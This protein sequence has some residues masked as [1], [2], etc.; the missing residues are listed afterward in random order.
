MSSAA[1]AYMAHWNKK[2]QFIQK[3]GKDNTRRVNPNG[4]NPYALLLFARKT[5]LKS[6][7]APSQI[8]MTLGH[9]S[10]QD[11]Q[12]WNL[13]PLYYRWNPELNCMEVAKKRY[14]AKGDKLPKELDTQEKKDAWYYPPEG[15]IEYVPLPPGSNLCFN[16]FGGESMR[17]IEDSIV[18]IMDLV[19]KLKNPEKINEKYDPE[20][21]Q[22]FFSNLNKRVGKFKP[23]A[24]TQTM[25]SLPTAMFH[26]KNPAKDQ[27]QQFV[28]LRCYDIFDES[29]TTD[30]A[31][32]R[33]VT[34]TR[35]MYSPSD[36]DWAFESKDKDPVKTL[37]VPI[38]ADKQGAGSNAKKRNTKC[39]KVFAAI[40]QRVGPIDS[41]VETISAKVTVWENLIEEVFHVKDVVLW[42][43]VM[44][45]VAS[46]MAPAVLL[47]TVGRD[48]T[49]NSGW[50][51]NQEDDEAGEFISLRTEEDVEGEGDKAAA[52]GSADKPA[53]SQDAVSMEDLERMLASKADEKKA[54][55]AQETTIANQKVDFFLDVTAQ[56]AW[57]DVYEVYRR[58][59][60]PV[61]PQW[62]MTPVMIN[63]RKDFRPFIASS[64]ST[65]GAFDFKRIKE[66]G[67]VICV[68]EWAAKIDNL[69]GFCELVTKGLGEFR[70]AVNTSTYINETLNQQLIKAIRTFTPQDGADFLDGKYSKTPVTWTRPENVEYALFFLNKQARDEKVVVEAVG[71]AKE[72]LSKFIRP[73]RIVY[74]AEGHM[75]GASMNAGAASQG[76][77][78]AAGFIEDGAGAAPDGT[79]KVTDVLSA[80]GGSAIA[81]SSAPMHVDSGAS[82]PTAGGDTASPSTPVKATEALSKKTAEK[83]VQDEERKEK[84][85][86]DSEGEPEKKKKKTPV[87][88]TGRHIKGN[89]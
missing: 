86:S 9:Y 26:L 20:N 87:K 78:L 85:A 39:M 40:Q 16:D 42:F 77:D 57:V 29:I 10:F 66:A 65:N 14:I 12:S 84:Q 41:R 79:P 80:M 71:Q 56:K 83:R 69:K 54:A 74:N 31:N 49:A 1:K 64:A 32:P 70:V 19:P 59:L 24:A 89:H 3:T 48:R 51:A 44:R 58:F 30:I 22:W 38:P 47:A 55:A 72:L 43:N 67:E 37:F 6:A 21:F 73:E 45:Y 76:E 52:D 4:F 36:D 61:P 68:S 15:Q 28:L 33:G 53:E 5:N 81:S 82:A 23:I 60:I 88:T 34:T 18:R 7:K 62:V 35:L 8:F 50:N 17:D 27:F 46:H 25:L 75:E 13:P 11:F 63:G 2:A